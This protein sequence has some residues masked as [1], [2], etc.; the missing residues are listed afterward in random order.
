MNDSHHCNINCCYC[1][2]IILA[3]KCLAAGGNFSL[4]NLAVAASGASIWP[5]LLAALLT[6]SGYWW[7]TFEW[8][9]IGG[10]N[11]K[12]VRGEYW[13]M[14]YPWGGTKGDKL[15]MC[16]PLGQ[17]KGRACQVLH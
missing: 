16:A 9:G 8:G 5:P 15:K 17:K 6:W 3:K 1:K 12:L 14:K 2:V 13:P 11:F 7:I 10:R 4:K